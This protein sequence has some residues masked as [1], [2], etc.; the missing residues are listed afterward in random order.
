MNPSAEPEQREY[1]KQLERL[2]DLIMD[3][4]STLKDP[5]MKPD[6]NRA[7]AL[8]NEIIAKVKELVSTP[9]PFTYPI[10]KT[11]LEWLDKPADNNP[12]L[13]LALCLQQCEKT[14]RIFRAQRL[15]SKHIISK[16]QSE[17]LS[18]LF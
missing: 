7:T 9:V 2:H 18:S 11:L 6:M 1:L 10:L 3:L 4:S 8:I 15:T 13:Y 5:T 14:D 17:L 12:D 16:F